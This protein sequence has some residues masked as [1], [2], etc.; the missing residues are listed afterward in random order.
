MRAY[1]FGLLF[2]HDLVKA[3]EW[4]VAH[5]KLTHRDPIALAASAA[6]AVGIARL[7]RGQ[8]WQWAASEMIAAAC[9]YCPKTGGMMARAYEE[10]TSGVGPRVTLDRLRGWAAHEAIAGA[11]YIFARH[12]ADPAAA[13]LEG[14]NTPGDS[15]SLATIAGA[16]AGCHAG[17]GR[18]PD[19]WI[20]DV[21]RSDELQQLALRI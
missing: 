10:A 6:M 7:M 11:L 15:D 18:L 20:T 17:V 14:T 5:S 4:A 19:E 1:P 3:E 9:R 13:I 2:A 8:P 21:E 12:P 16:L